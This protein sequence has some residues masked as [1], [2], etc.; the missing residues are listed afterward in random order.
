V[1]NYNDRRRDVFSMARAVTHE[2]IALSMWSL[3][4]NRT[5][6]RKCEYD[7]SLPR[8]P[9]LARSVHIGVAAHGFRPR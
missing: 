8:E 6:Y 4:T 3:S 2:R 9:K 7:V 5:D 1:C